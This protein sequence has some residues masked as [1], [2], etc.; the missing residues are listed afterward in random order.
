LLRIYKSRVVEVT[1]K[2][3]KRRPEHISHECIGGLPKGGFPLLQF[4][5]DVVHRPA[6][7]FHCLLSFVKP[8]LDSLAER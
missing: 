4:D 6:L 7:L 3:F 8:L 2:C 1:S 5:H